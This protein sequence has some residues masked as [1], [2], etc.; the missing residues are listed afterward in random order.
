MNDILRHDTLCRLCQSSDLEIILPL[1]DTPLED[2]FVGRP[3]AH[4]P[5]PFYPLQVALCKACGY[6]RLP[7]II[8]PEASYDNYAY[9]SSVT[10]GLRDH[11][12]AYARSVKDKFQ[13]QAGALAVDLGSN[14][15][16]MLAALKNCGLRALGVEPA[17]RIA[18]LA[19]QAGLPTLNAFFDPTTAQNIIEEHGKASLVTANYMYA[20]VDDVMQFTQCVHSLLNEDGVF[21]IQTG[22]HPEQFKKFMF[23]YVYH[24]HFSYFTVQVLSKIFTR[25]GLKLL[26]A[27]VTAP[28]G[29]SIRVTACKQT[30]ARIPNPSVARIRDKEQRERV[31]DSET[32][33]VFCR[34]LEGRRTATRSKLEEI[35]K[36]GLRIVGFGASHSTTTLTCHFGLNEFIEYIADDNPSKHGTYSPGYRIPVFA[37]EKLSI[38]KPDV[39]IIMA[40][41]HAKTI[42]ERHSH[43]F[44]YNARIIV[45]LPELR[46]Y[47]TLDDLVGIQL[48]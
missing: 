25:C 12:L 24:E 39:I 40:W 4:R 8:S 6:V 29:G 36:A 17:S 11:Y 15:G 30:S 45:P 22:Y 14:D 35:K 43:L 42:L 48:G 31:H 34:E 41:Q 7:H 38:D 26:D 37:S 19:N 23:D 5:D 9:E 32:Y 21:V 1:A 3:D 47:R 28:K 2:R 20:N 33:K 27:E 46:E 10:V 18:Q 44:E 16:S 13:I